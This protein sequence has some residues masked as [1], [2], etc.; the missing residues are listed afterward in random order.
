MS[1]ISENNLIPVSLSDLKAGQRIEKRT[2]EVLEIH[3][4]LMEGVTQ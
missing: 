2:A 3:N 4:T 1:E